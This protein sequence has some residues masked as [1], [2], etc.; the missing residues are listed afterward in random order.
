MKLKVLP[1]VTLLVFLFLSLAYA[2]E[3]QRI[4]S[5]ALKAA[6]EGDP[7]YAFMSFRYLLS[8][9]PDSKHREAALFATGEYYFLIG[10][11]TD[12]RP[13]FIKFVDEYPNSKVRPF[14]LAYLIKIAEKQDQE[15][16]AESMEKEIITSQQL[17]LLFRDFKEF[18]YLSPLH[19]RYKAVHFIDK[20][21]FYIDG[22]LF[23]QI[24]Y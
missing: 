21:E 20:I 6:K 16:L 3:S 11:Y 17:I 5:L 22:E 15:A 23:A 12:A 9:Y 10:D 8:N 1:I 13:V 14:A 24:S 2:Q 18:R 19:R 7:G 4:Y